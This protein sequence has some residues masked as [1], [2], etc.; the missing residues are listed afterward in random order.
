MSVGKIILKSTTRMSL[1][2]RFTVLRQEKP[3]GQGQA[4]L[5]LEDR[6]QQT[7]ASRRNQ[8]LAAQME[9]RPAVVAALKL[10][11]KSV[12]QRLNGPRPLSVKQR[13][14]VKGRLSVPDEAGM[15][16]LITRGR[17]GLRGLRGS[18]FRGATF[19]GAVSR[20]G[21]GG[22][23]GLR[24]RGAITGGRGTITGGRGALTGG[25]GIGRGG[26]G[27]R[28]L[29]GRGGRGMFQGRGGTR[30]GVRGRGFAAG[31]GRG[32]NRAWPWRAHKP[33][34]TWEQR[35]SW[36]N[37]CYPWGKLDS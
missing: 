32:I 22:A 16:S 28:F 17:G 6:R 18:N 19:R 34:G 29:R 12:E 3:T 24:G 31:Q 8:R 11:K 1:N 5:G 27:G 14:A 23:I 20:G 4:A 2:D 21:R 10:K 33:R 25:R 26:R 35:S 30:G 9:R 13:L 7:Q 15:G 36:R 37:H